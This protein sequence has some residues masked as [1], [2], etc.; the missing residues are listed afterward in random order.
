[1]KKLIF[2]FILTVILCG[3]PGCTSSRATVKTDTDSSTRQTVQTDSSRSQQTTASEQLAVALKGSEQ[4]SVVVEFEEWEYYPATADTASGHEAPPAYNRRTKGETDKPPNAGAV[5]R[6]KKGTITINADRQMTAS[7]E[8]SST[9]TDSTSAAGSSEATLEN[10]TKDSTS[11]KSER[12]AGSQTNAF[13]WGAALTLAAILAA[14][15]Y[16]RRK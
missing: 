3:L 13:L 16:F 1:M 8:Q 15:I 14:L 11:R 10:D 9:R 5:K 12:K 2:A 4:K 7:S 6:H